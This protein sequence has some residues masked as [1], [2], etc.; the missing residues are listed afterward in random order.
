MLRRLFS[1]LLAVAALASPARA[2]DELVVAM[3]QAPGTMNPL[4]SSMLA[5]SLI[6]NMT[7]RPIT[8]YDPGWK[9]V[10]LICTELPSL[11]KGTARLVDLPDG[12]KGIETDIELK[13]LAWGDGTPVT[14][15]DVAFTIEVGKHPLSGV[16]S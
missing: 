9:L 11:E 2:K 10:C 3:T 8:A 5:K 16:A 6:L 1:L 13:R 15:K 4:I 7:Q 14:T 12:K